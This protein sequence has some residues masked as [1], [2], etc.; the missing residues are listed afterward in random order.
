MA[1]AKPHK[2]PMCSNSKLSKYI[3]STF[4][5]P[6]LYRSTVGALQY[7]AL[8]LPDIA[9]IVNKVCQFMQCP[10]DDHWTAVKRIFRYLKHTG[11]HGLHIW[12]SSSFV[13]S[14]FSDADWADCPYDRRSVGRY[15]IYL[16]PNLISWTSQKQNIVSCCS[17]ES[18]YRGL[19]IATAEVSW[20]GSLLHELGVNL[21]SPPILWCD[22]LGATYLTINPV[23]HARTKHIENN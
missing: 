11:Y 16:G 6:S 23:F 12:P 9:F 17:T 3:V 2:T 5:D 4:H 21:S 10:T 18:E 1:D 14:T 13:L 15:C 22:N 7:L 19:A 20:I 8:T